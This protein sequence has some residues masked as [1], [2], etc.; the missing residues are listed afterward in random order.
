MNLD[1]LLGGEE[2]AGLPADRTGAGPNLN[3]FASPGP[4]TRR[5]LPGRGPG[6][7]AAAAATASPGI[8]AEGLTFGD[9][10]PGM[11]GWGLEGY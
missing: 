9:L 5:T 4:F 8:S 1:Q 6:A 2:W 11:L 10:T 7:A 3:A